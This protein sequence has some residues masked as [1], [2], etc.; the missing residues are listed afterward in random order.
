MT[1]PERAGSRCRGDRGQIGGIE[2]LPFGF[3]LFVAVVLLIANAWAVIDARMAVGA[4]A[5]EAARALV[6]SERGDPLAAA[7]RRAREVLDAYGRGEDHR[8]RVVAASV[9][10][11][12]VARCA[13]ARVTVEYEVPALVVPFLGGFGEG[14]TV[15]G[16][17]TE[18]IDPYRDGLPEGRCP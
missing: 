12:V 16:R 2:V 10:G 4:A 7:E 6:E 5:R 9:D 8:V 18:L 15:R 3:L 13:R 14:I 17:H 11:G 1:Q